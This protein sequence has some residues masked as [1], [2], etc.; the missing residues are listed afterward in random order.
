MHVCVCFHVLVILMLNVG[1]LL[2]LPCLFALQGL[3][4]ICALPCALYYSKSKK[5]ERLKEVP[6][7]LK[8]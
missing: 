2:D 1:N 8:E 4:D 6:V 5:N 3:L 7:G